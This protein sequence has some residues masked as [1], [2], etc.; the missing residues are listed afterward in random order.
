MGVSVRAMPAREK[1]RL[2]SQIQK[3]GCW[4]ETGCHSLLVVV[5]VLLIKR[6]CAYQ[7]PKKEGLQ[8]D[9][10]NPHDPDA[11]IRKIKDGRSHVA[12]IAEHAVDLETGFAS[13]VSFFSKPEPVSSPVL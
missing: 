3:G 12:H 7:D 13:P 5:C 1:A 6:G 10:K 11:Q 2:S 8:Y 9:C 4:L